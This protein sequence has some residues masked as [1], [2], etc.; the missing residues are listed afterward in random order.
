MLCRPDAFAH[1]ADD[2]Q[3]RETHISWVILAGNY[4]YKI[5]KPVDFGFLDFSS[6]ERRRHFCER[7]LELNSRFAP[8]LYLAVVPITE[9]GA[10]PVIGGKGEVLEYAVQ[11][12]RFDESQLLDAVARRGGL[13]LELLRSLARELADLHDKLPICHPDPAT[14]GPGTPAALQAA[15]EENFRQVTAYPLAPAQARQVEKIRAWT[16]EQYA[17]QHSTMQSR[18]L[19]GKVIDGH[20]DVHL[21]NIAVIEGRVRLFD[22]IEFNPAFRIIDSIGEI[23]LLTMDLDAREHPAE[24]HRL[25]SDYLEYRGDYAGLALL[26]LY[27]S[28]YA[29]VRAKV[30]LLRVDADS[31]GLQDTD[32]YKEARR[33]LAFASHYCEPQRPFLAITHGLSGSGKS[34]LAA[35]LVAASGAVRIRSDVERKRQFGLSPEQR[36]TAA[37]QDRLYSRSV[38]ARTFER[39]ESL[40]SQVLA[41]GF[42][43]IIDAT[44]LHRNARDRFRN[45]AAQLQVPFAIMACAEPDPVLRERLRERDRRQHDASEAGVLVME[46][47]RQALESLTAAEQEVSI[48]A[49]SR[50]APAELWRRLEDVLRRPRGAE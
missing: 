13:D 14:D 28:Y 24:S 31:H 26:N 2:L 11:M 22:C 8:E 20:G 39:L 32:A 7:E 27:R 10:G 50:E 41:S 49:R 34:T 36:S 44:F 23:G 6:L 45:L 42:A 16:R 15:F 43:V 47:Q 12:R 46:Q 18:V 5:K 3:L 29:L 21:G 30:N 4:A 48:T 17:L 33:Y 25:L 38:T 9:T 35:N 40:A 19:E 1:P 37:Q